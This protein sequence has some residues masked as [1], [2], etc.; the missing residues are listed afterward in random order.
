MLEKIV[1]FSMNTF[2]PLKWKTTVSNEP[3]QINQRLKRVIRDRQKALARRDMQ[4]R[5]LNY[6]SKVKHSKECRPA[7]WWKEVRKLSGLSATEQSSVLQHID[8]REESSPHSLAN[9]IN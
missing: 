8:C 7:A 2:F 1:N 6:E 9:S 5:A 3:S 4:C